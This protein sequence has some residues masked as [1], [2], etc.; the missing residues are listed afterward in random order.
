MFMRQLTYLV[1]LD[2]HRHFA[3]AAESCHVS[4][5][6][7]S[8]GISELERELGITI[9]KRNRSFQ[10]ITPEGE[11]VLIWA[12][13]VLASLDGLR[14][15]ADLVRAV[16]GGHLAIGT[17]P[18]AVQAITLLADEYRRLIP[19]LTLGVYALSTK[20]I[21]QRLKKHELHLG[22]TYVQSAN[23]E[24][25]DVLP[26]FTERYV[27]V[28]GGQAA[29]PHTMSWEDVA[30]LPLCLFS[31]E[32]QNRRIIDDAFQAAG[33]RPRVVLETNTIGVLYS[34]ARSGRVFSIMP[35]S[36]LPAYLVDMGIRIH[37]ITPERASSV[38][39]LRLRRDVQ[40]PILEAVWKLGASLDV[41]GILD[42]PLT[43]IPR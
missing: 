20:D 7:L 32:M 35:I 9:I 18:S 21:L 10:G 4:Q 34:E 17:V 22:V 37:P 12:R 13:Q 30:E 1:A 36:A 43:A 11:R 25:F 26:L 39:L 6:A 16:P 19:D 2:Q 15:E 27:L 23:Q 8:A 24:E 31:Q 40:P 38:G 5:P 33:A 29:L 3:R 42:A 41:Q 14:Q 28:A